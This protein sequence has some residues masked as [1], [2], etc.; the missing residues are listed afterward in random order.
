MYLSLMGKKGLREVAEQSLRKAAYLRSKLASIKGVELPFAGPVYNE[1]VVRTTRPASDV[2]AAL[3]QSKILGGIPL[4]EFYDGHDRDI[5][6][7]VTE[8]HTREQLDQYAGA[9]SA[10]V[11]GERR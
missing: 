1:F 11:S 6:V 5:L 9:F 8:M 2:L 3:E 7:A 4:S 10:A